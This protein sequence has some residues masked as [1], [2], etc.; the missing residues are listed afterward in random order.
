[1]NA[2]ILKTAPL[3][4]PNPDSLYIKLESSFLLACPYV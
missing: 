3:F 1:M 4:F 2:L